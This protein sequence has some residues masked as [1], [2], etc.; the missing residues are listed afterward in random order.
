MGWLWRLL[1]RLASA[2]CELGGGAIANRAGRVVGRPV[3]FRLFS[4]SWLLLA[5]CSGGDDPPNGPIASDA[6]L[7]DLGNVVIHSDGG[8]PP[9]SGTALGCSR[10]A[11]A[12][13]EVGLTTLAEYC[14]VSSAGSAEVWVDS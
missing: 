14:S 8:L 5:A 2:P 7:V 4:I 6:G 1:A 10:D 12:P 9:D 3:R 11:G 13:A